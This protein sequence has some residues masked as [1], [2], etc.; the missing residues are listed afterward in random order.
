MAEFEFVSTFDLPSRDLVSLPDQSTQV[1]VDADQSPPVDLR[2]GSFASFVCHLSHL[3]TK[4]RG[5]TSL[6]LDESAKIQKTGRILGS[7][8][9]FLVRQAS[10]I[11]DPNDPPL[12]VA[13]K[14]IIPET[15]T[16]GR[17]IR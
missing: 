1:D 6:V 5:F 16:D 13:L 17:P 2:R 10:W 7:G 11:K 12:D 15:V 8:K 4:L 3:D 14:E 9:T